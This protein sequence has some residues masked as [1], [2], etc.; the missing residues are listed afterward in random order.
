[1]TAPSGGFWPTGVSGRERRV[2]VVVERGPGSAGAGVNRWQ[3]SALSAGLSWRSNAR[4][5]STQIARPCVA[6][7]EVVAVDQQIARPRRRQVLPQRLPIVAVVE[8]DEHAGLVAGIEQARPDRIGADRA[9]DL[10]G[11]EG[12]A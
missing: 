2:M 6:A 3:L 8:A 9:D 4:S 12:R 10:A 1:M 7:I 5:P 11:R